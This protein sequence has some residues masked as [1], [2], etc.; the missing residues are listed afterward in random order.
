MIGRA[1]LRRL[2]PLGVLLGA[3]ACG[4]TESGPGSVTSET[5]LT[6][7][8]VVVDQCP[9]RG[10][11][12]QMRGTEGGSTW[13]DLGVHGIEARRALVGRRVRASGTF[14]AR[15]G[16]TWLIARRL[17]VLPDSPSSRPNRMDP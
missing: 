4:G 8:G 13:V 12:L 11:W 14:E 9:A 10:C 3:L 15:G 5:V 7:E 6:L 17:D 1:I 16:H 2:V